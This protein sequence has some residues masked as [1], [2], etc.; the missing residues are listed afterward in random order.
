MRT[1]L[2]KTLFRIASRAYQMHQCV[3][4][5]W[6]VGHQVCLCCDTAYVDAKARRRALKEKC[7]TTKKSLDGC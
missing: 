7:G 4:G 1:R 2:F 3:C 5:R 6:I